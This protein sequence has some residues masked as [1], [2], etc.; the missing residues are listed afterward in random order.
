MSL[1]VKEL[2]IKDDFCGHIIQ[3]NVLGN[4][5]A[6]NGS[7]GYLTPKTVKFVMAVSWWLFF[8]LSLHSESTNLSIKVIGRE[9]YIH[10]C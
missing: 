5:S 7:A 8:F 9:M 6:M 2:G 4:L 10:L 3:V 1:L